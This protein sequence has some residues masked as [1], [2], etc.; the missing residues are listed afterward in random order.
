M[1]MFFQYLLSDVLRI[2]L[3]EKLHTFDSKYIN[4]LMLETNI[5]EICSLI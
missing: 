3:N 5:N 4:A 2:F 1:D